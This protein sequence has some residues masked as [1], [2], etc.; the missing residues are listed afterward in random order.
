VKRYDAS[1][2]IGGPRITPEGRRKLL[3]T[4]EIKMEKINTN[5]LKVT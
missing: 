5:L 1:Q 2:I 4:I 3:I